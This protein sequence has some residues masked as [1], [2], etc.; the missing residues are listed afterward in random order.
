[1]IGFRRFQRAF[2]DIR[3]EL[4]LIE[5]FGVGPT[6]LVLDVG[7]GQNP[8]LRADVLCDYFLTD[9]SERACGG[10]PVV[11]RPLVVADAERRLPFRDAAF[12]FVVCSHL[13]EHVRRPERLLSELRRVARR[14]Y[15]ETPH[16]VHEQL[17]GNPFHKWLVSLD[18]SGL[19]LSP[20]PRAHPNGEPSAWFRRRYEENQRFRDLV[21]LHL[22]DFGFL[23]RYH[24][25]GEI[26]FTLEGDLPEGGDFV[27]AAAS[28]SPATVGS[29]LVGP[30]QKAR[31]VIGRWLRRASPLDRKMLVNLLRCSRCAGPL[32]EGP[33]LRCDRGH[34]F[35]VSGHFFYLA[36]PFAERGGDA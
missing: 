33:T 3:A 15:I 16:R 32:F 21:N 9:H 20:K 23:V 24:W 29:G 5:S 27:F 28:H 6:D 22:D 25:N 30:R 18:D 19:R 12:D 1:V 14:G 10:A 35:P 26:R 2:V 4:R 17:Y 31:S 36:E 34:R 7:S 11:D 8:N 13:L